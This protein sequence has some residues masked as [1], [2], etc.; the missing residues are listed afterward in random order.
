MGFKSTASLKL[1]TIVQDRIYRGDS[2]FT[3]ENA[4]RFL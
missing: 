3:A 4:I 2:D 1:G